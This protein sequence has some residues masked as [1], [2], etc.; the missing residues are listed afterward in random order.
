MDLPDRCQV[1]SSANRV[2]AQ[3]L[4]NA[5]HQTGEIPSNNESDGVE[6]PSTDGD[7][8]MMLDS[9]PTQFQQ[10]RVPINVIQFGSP[11]PEF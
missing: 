11:V 9:D 10:V 5:L 4:V 8:V 3:R 1:L 7:S 2:L 6:Q